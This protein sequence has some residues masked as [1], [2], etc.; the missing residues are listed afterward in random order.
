MKIIVLGGAGML[1]HKM[2]QTLREGFPG[3]ACTVREDPS[4]PPLDGVDLL[5][6]DDVLRGVDVADAPALERLLAGS[7]PDVI[8]N[9]VGVIKQIEDGR[10]AVPCIAL[11]ALLP[12][13]LALLAA[14]WGGRVIH[15]ST[16]CVFDGTRG[17]Y[18]EDDVPDARDLYGKTKALGEIAYDNALT[19]R[20]SFIGREL[21]R[22]LSLLEW[23]LAQDGKTVKGFGKV[24]Y[25]G[26]TT[27]EIAGIVARLVTGNPGLSGLFQVASQ[28]VSKHDLLLL[29]R[30]AFGLDVEILRDDSVV[31]DRSMQGRRFAEATGVTVP[32]WEDMVRALA[33][34][35]TPYGRW[36]GRGR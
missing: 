32:P 21:D 36:K 14:R 35:P 34:D 30:E 11:N 33:E 5:Q 27:L 19:L 17:G 28:P 12:H 4:T 15:F 22:N 23:F 25:S 26:V 2:F 9:C 10:S 31:S 18:T 7:E 1:G 3:V 29:L 24:L 8:V 6:G 13:Q 16:D 20:T